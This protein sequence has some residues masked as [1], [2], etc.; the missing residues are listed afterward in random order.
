MDARQQILETIRT[1]IKQ[2]SQLPDDPPRDTLIK[3]TAIE[4]QT[5]E[6]KIQ[7][8][9]EEL[10]AVS[11]EFLEA[12]ST[13][14]TVDKISA[15]LKDASVEEVVVSG[16]AIIDQ[17]A[18]ALAE[19]GIRIHRPEAL[20]AE[21]RKNRVASIIVGIV[22]AAYAVADTAT[23]AIPFT[24]HS[25]LPHFL[26]EI[27]IALVSS[28][29]LVGNHFE[30]F[31]TLPP[32]VRKNMLLVTGPSRTADIEKILILGAHGPRR[33]IACIVENTV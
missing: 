11:G 33:L 9:K 10:T 29:S 28:Q 17:L 32:E 27:V 8:F 23:L 18:S 26:P 20:P 21:S 12:A 24:G 31:A 14:E 13:A 7:R 25:P 6:E 22:E 16:G 30:L 1:A 5:V 3:A 4:P 19:R 15:I 2:N